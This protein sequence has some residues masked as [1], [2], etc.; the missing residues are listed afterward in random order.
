MSGE[1]FI[2][3]GIVGEGFAQRLGEP[4]GGGG[5]GALLIVARAVI[6]PPVRVDPHARVGGAGG[7]LLLQASPVDV[8]ERRRRRGDSRVAPRGF[9]QAENARHGRELR[10]RG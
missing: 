6:T 10:L 5:D 3:E 8:R 4:G 9:A 2:A 1:E 7:L